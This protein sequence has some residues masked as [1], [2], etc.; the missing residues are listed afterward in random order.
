MIKSFVTKCVYAVAVMLIVG[1]AFFALR[2]PQGIPG[3]I[4][5]RREIQALEERNS[6]LARENEEKR[7]RISRLRDNQ[8]VQELEIR[9]RL[10]LVKPDEKVFILQD[11]EKK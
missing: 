11:Q 6:V 1:Y 8:T 5:K 4:E 2:G 7:A 10:K 3:L 9:R